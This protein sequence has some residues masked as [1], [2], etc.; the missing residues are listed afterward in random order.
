MLIYVSGIPLPLVL[1]FVG[2][3]SAR[4]IFGAHLYQHLQRSKYSKLVKQLFQAPCGLLTWFSGGG[5]AV[6]LVACFET[7]FITI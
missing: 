4:K 2:R 7:T 3:L 5:F 1:G 6:K